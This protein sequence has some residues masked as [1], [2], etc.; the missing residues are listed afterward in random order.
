MVAESRIE[1][2]HPIYVPRDEAF[3]ELKQ[4]AF[5]A[6]RLR[7]VLHS[8]IPSLIAS[9]SAD[10]HDFQGF[11]HIDNLYKEGL[12]LKLGLQ[13]HLIKKLPFVRKIQESSE[14]LLRYDTPRILSSKHCFAWLRDDEFARQAVAGINPVSIERL[15]VTLLSHIHTITRAIRNEAPCSNKGIMA[16]EERKLFMLDFHD[17]YLPFIERINAMDGRKA[18]ATRTLFFLNPIGTLKPVA[19]ELGLPPAQPGASRPSM[20]LTPPRDATTNWLWMLGKAHVGS[21][22][23]G[24]HQLVNHWLRTHASMEPFILA[25]YRQ[26]SAM[27]PV[28]KLL[29]PHM[30]YTLEINALARQSLINADGVIESCFTPGA[31]C[32]EMSAAYYKHHWRFD[33]EGLPADLIRRQVLHPPSN[34]PIERTHQNARS[35]N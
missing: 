4:G 23:A 27:H 2:P 13:E 8:F 1:K 32:M 11:H 22:E 9:I 33:F 31:V 26:L 16:V 6:G 20:V 28:F 10:N 24:V 7:A 14:G 34:L 15:Q 19:I 5:S 30:R 17:I 29:H 12:V 3:E 35:Y 18:Y 25:A 21:N